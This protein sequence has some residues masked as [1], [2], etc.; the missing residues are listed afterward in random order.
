MSEEPN[1]S[2]LPTPIIDLITGIPKALIPASVKAIDRLISAGID[3]PVAWL[4]QKKAQIEAQTAAY[5]AVESA[6]AKT[7]AA[8]AGASPAIVDQAMKVLVRKAYRKHTNLVA[9]T[10]ATLES[11]ASDPGIPIDEP[12][13]PNC[14]DEDWLNLFERFAEDASTEKMQILWGRLLAGEIRRPGRF[15][16]RT[17][18]FISEVSQVEAQSF[19]DI[20]EYGF[21]DFIPRKLVNEEN[22][23]FKKLINLEALGLI[24]GVAAPIVHRLKFNAD[25]F[26][27]LTEPPWFIGFKGP[28]DSQKQNNA[29]MLTK[30]GVELL[31]LLPERDPKKCAKRV[32]E[33]VRD[34]DIEFAYYS[35]EGDET[36]AT[37]AFVWQNDTAAEV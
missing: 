21:G 9:V 7:V 22:E 30:I 6:I 16:L 10:Q 33:A 29:L 18:R 26:A 27:F 14:P 19:A 34:P 24:Q 20:A 3:I 5:S 12:I 25:G 2:N 1:L 31:T 8:E 28:A 35:I 15:S 17:L 32:S 13:A 23:S 4:G 37:R 36:F 11:L